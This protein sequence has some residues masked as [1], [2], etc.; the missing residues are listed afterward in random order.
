MK[1]RDGWGTNRVTLTHAFIPLIK[2]EEDKRLLAVYFVP[3]ERGRV[4]SK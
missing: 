4:Y 1:A 2:S 3:E